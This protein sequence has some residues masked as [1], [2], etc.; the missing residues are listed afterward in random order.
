MILH[1]WFLE[2][3]MILDRWKWHYIV[4]GDND[5]PQK[6]ILNS[7]EITSF[8]EQKLLG[9]KS[10]FESHIRSLCEKAGQNVC[11]LTKIKHFLTSVHKI[12]LFDSAVVH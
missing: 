10:K 3:Y 12:L 2:N 5:P 7:N 1:K 11:A 6:I 8:N 9:K 4:I